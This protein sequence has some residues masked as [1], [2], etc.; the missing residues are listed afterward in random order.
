[1]GQEFLSFFPGTHLLNSHTL[2]D[3]RYDTANATIPINDGSLN[4]ALPLTT[5]N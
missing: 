2:E 1:M 4:H 3:M 5:G